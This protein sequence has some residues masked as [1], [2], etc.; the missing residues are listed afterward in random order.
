VPSSCLTMRGGMPL[1]LK[2]NEFRLRRGCQ[3]LPTFRLNG[4]ASPPSP[5]GVSEACPRARA[6]RQQSARL[7]C[8]LPLR[9]GSG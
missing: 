5:G 3:L 7:R 4:T 8:S 1:P 2:G 9:A 6:V